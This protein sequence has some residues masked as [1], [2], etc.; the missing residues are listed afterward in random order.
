[1][2][3]TISPEL[4]GDSVLVPG[5]EDQQTFRRASAAANQIR[6]FTAVDSERHPI[7]LSFADVSLEALYSA[8]ASRRAVVSIRRVCLLLLTLVLTMSVMELA[9]TQQQW[10]SAL[11]AVL[12]LRGITVM[13]VGMLGISADQTWT[14]RRLRRS[15]SALFVG[16]SVLLVTASIVGSGIRIP[17]PMSSGA[18]LAADGPYFL[19]PL[20]WWTSIQDV[21]LVVAAHTSG[22]PHVLTTCVCA[23]HWVLVVGTMVASTGNNASVPETLAGFT[24]ALAVSMAAV[25][26]YFKENSAR[27]EFVYMRNVTADKRRRDG[28]LS[29][30]LP[31]RI[32]ARL[33]D[34]R[35]VADR[36]DTT[37]EN[38]NTTGGDSASVLY[39]AS[40]AGAAVSGA[41]SSGAGGVEHS[42]AASSSSKPER[43]MA[44]VAPLPAVDALTAPA[45]ASSRTASGLSGS[46]GGAGSAAP[47]VD[48]TSLPGAEARPTLA[49]PGLVRSEV[50]SALSPPSLRQ[51][52]P[53][54]QPSRLPP[55]TSSSLTPTARA[56]ST[57]ISIKA[58]A[59]AGSQQRRR[60]HRGV[61]TPAVTEIRFR[62]RRTIAGV[63]QRG[64]TAIAF[65]ERQSLAS[66]AE[67]PSPTCGPAQTPGLAS[68]G[69]FLQRVD[70]VDDP[71]LLALSGGSARSPFARA[72][73]QFGH[74]AANGRRRSVLSR[75]QELALRGRSEPR[76]GSAIDMI[77]Q[78][79]EEA[80]EDMASQHEPADAPE[81]PEQ[82]APTDSHPHLDLTRYDSDLRQ[83]SAKSLL[84]RDG[85]SEAALRPSGHHGVAIGDVVVPS[86]PVQARIVEAA[87]A[88]RR[89][90]SQH[91]SL[92]ITDGKA[93]APSPRK[94]GH[95]KSS[96]SN[97][98]DDED[99][100]DEAA[101]R[102]AAEDALHRH[103]DTAMVT[104]EV[105]QGNQP[106]KRLADLNGVAF[107]HESVS[108]MFV[109]VEGL[110]T[111]SN[112][113]SPLD[114]V[115][116]LN[117]LYVLF[118]AETE[119][120][121]VYKVMA[122][123]NMY[124]AVAGA[125]EPD[126]F[127][128][129]RVCDAADRFL[130]IVASSNLMFGKEPV[131]VK[132]GINSGPVA[133]GVIGRRTFN[134]HIFGDT[135]NV[136]SR[137]CSTAESMT[138]HLSR[139]SAEMVTS[140]DPEG[141]GRRLVSRGETMVKGKGMM[142]TS[143]LSIPTARSRQL[144]ARRGAWG[145]KDGRADDAGESPVNQVVSFVRRMA[146][147]LPGGGSTAA[148]AGGSV[149]DATALPGRLVASSP[150]H[151]RDD[152]DG[153]FLS[154]RRMSYD[155][156]LVRETSASSPVDARNASIGP[157]T[158]SVMFAGSGSYRRAS[159]P[160][161]A[162][163]SEAPSPS[164]R[165]PPIRLA[166]SSRRLLK[167]GG[168]AIAQPAV[169]VSS[170]QLIRRARSYR[171][172]PPPTLRRRQSRRSQLDEDSTRVRIERQHRLLLTFERAAS[173][174]KRLMEMRYQAS[175]N[176]VEPR[177]VAVM[178]R[179]MAMVVLLYDLFVAVVA[180][181]QGLT[182][183]G[184][185][186]WAVMHAGAVLVPAFAYVV[187]LNLVVWPEGRHAELNQQRRAMGLPILSRAMSVK[188]WSPTATH[189]TALLACFATFVLLTAPTSID[190]AST[191]APL[192]M[193]LVF[194]NTFFTLRAVHVAALNTACTVVFL[195]IMSIPGSRPAGAVLGVTAGVVFTTVLTVIH[196]Y[197][198]E[199]G[200]RRKYLIRRHAF[201]QAKKC[202]SLLRN[203]LP[204]S[205]HVERLMRG[206]I[207]VETLPEVALLY[208]DI[209]GFTQLSSELTHNQLIHLLH[210][211][212]T[213]FDTHLD[214]YEG[215]Y[216]IET[217]G[218]AFIV[219][220][221]LGRAMHAPAHA[222]QHE[223]AASALALSGRQNRK[224]DPSMGISLGIGLGMGGDGIGLGMGGDKVQVIP[225]QD[226][227]ELSGSPTETSSHQ[228]SGTSSTRGS[229][230]F[231]SDRDNV[232]GS[233]AGFHTA[234]ASFRLGSLASRRGSTGATP[235]PAQ[236]RQ[237]RERFASAGTGLGAGKRRGS[238]AKPARRGFMPQES[239]GIYDGGLAAV[240]AVHANSDF[241][242][243]TEYDEMEAS[244][245]SEAAK[246][247]QLRA[248]V[249]HRRPLAPGHQSRPETPGSP[250]PDR[251][252]PPPPE[253]K[254]VPPP[255]AVDTNSSY[256]D[257]QRK[258]A[259]WTAVRRLS[260]VA[261]DD[262]SVP[263][264]PPSEA[265]VA[266]ARRR[267][268]DHSRGSFMGGRGRGSDD[269]ETSTGASSE[270]LSNNPTA[271]MCAFAL[272]M[273]DE[274]FELK[275][276]YGLPDFAM[277]IGIH[278]GTVVGGVIGSH[279]PR[280]FV[281]GPDTVVGNAMESGCPVGQ[282]MLSEAAHE[283][284]KELQ[285]FEFDTP[286]ALTVEGQ[287]INTMLLRGVGDRD[288]PAIGARVEMGATGEHVLRMPEPKS[289]AAPEPPRRPHIPSR[290][291]R[292]VLAMGAGMLPA[293]D[294]RVE[295][296][297]LP[298]AE[299]PGGQLHVLDEDSED[300]GS[301]AP[302]A[303]VPGAVLDMDA[304]PELCGKP[305]AAMFRL[306]SGRLTS[307]A[308]VRDGYD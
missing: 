74:A 93:P 22:L 292:A 212:Y 154:S 97:G 100:D 199:S 59:S 183:T 5:I 236:Q 153:S 281:W 35:D 152:S 180:L 301:T 288:V 88:A 127:H 291:S 83:L 55:I 128:I 143:V 58:R 174:G 150:N 139:A 286:S 193:I 68:N 69:S 206:D 240:Q 198:S 157:R 265:Q 308:S 268:S 60:K 261:D 151:D 210:D 118:D 168:S 282:V 23:F 190:Q 269:D 273:V 86:H 173:G 95:Q 233:G 252:A 47:A 254:Q 116:T 219:I 76:R 194:A 124:L 46:P 119:R 112:E 140:V 85:R 276:A 169:A 111:A 75:A 165:A 244:R 80:P 57:P 159:A 162:G 15:A 79:L 300:E 49:L 13:W 41:S 51:M 43:S 255:M 187:L 40:E 37:E 211:L 296:H 113:V 232:R 202:Q 135:V 201:D 182:P 31:P 107:S 272:D 138:T 32:K 110:D 126:P 307:E 248:S 104:D 12:I 44:A 87:E 263:M 77:R 175:R 266:I 27:S 103:G 176:R 161:V 253:R 277:R 185:S 33:K 10:D 208:S 132:V 223:L 24:L 284:V 131:R 61:K 121:G 287:S 213:A 303:M 9:W 160:T 204:S 209:V 200:Q 42:A 67:P 259:T 65:E 56:I 84:D 191:R 134:Y 302:P 50:T 305:H 141:W 177:V 62:P 2:L 192:A 109:Y 129:V 230:V 164:S 207:I 20:S 90:S 70:D 239:K 73:P 91:R 54:S 125:P 186:L 260:G 216:K 66:G 270:D 45:G 114:L 26:A 105:G 98:A 16:A 279:R 7:F 28:L 256:D 299:G 181:P 228:A 78:A 81:A 245:A 156:K 106:S 188:R 117:D 123:A 237:S 82:P 172:P 102:L 235:A 217:I 52:S 189:W 18:S 25:M 283:Q 184:A 304:M 297:P 89:M 63:M 196:A 149:N 222:S 179:V 264:A 99:D 280:Y 262:D 275:N 21:S 1:M 214:N 64:V 19:R 178:L 250:S 14:P 242:V 195:V 234:A 295:Q 238:P 147:L 142:A 36:A 229:D 171:I 53:A 11:T 115:R 155:A 163:H 71:G 225:R 72:P 146:S 298:A 231:G 108:V 224:F 249:A 148:T 221:G 92:R 226:L 48:L 247:R 96:N 289:R 220:G 144:S 293:V 274:I 257:E 241:G 29:Q 246:E 267:L 136:A 34:R 101:S 243:A 4:L 271:A 145:N 6:H 167:S 306:G 137:M 258:Q 290:G 30:M 133:A 17:E 94:S 218:D 120:T 197:S 8:Y 215:L 158:P 294:E 251:R 39:E 227:D 285:A 205:S 278:V 203:M 38:N 130:S 3:R 166:N 170:H 122:I